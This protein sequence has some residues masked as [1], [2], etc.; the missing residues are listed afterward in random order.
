[1]NCYSCHN[2]DG[3]GTWRGPDLTKRVPTLSDAQIV[4][5]IDEGPGLMPAFKGKIDA[6]ETQ[7]VIAWLRERF[8]HVGQ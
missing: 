1:V 8:P 2:G 4:R 3:T 5:T 7:Q 6:Q